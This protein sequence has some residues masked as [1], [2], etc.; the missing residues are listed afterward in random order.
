MAELGFCQ[1]ALLLV[2]GLCSARNWP[3]IPEPLPMPSLGIYPTCLTRHLAK[4]WSSSPSSWF[5]MLSWTHAR[6]LYAS[7]S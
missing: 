5:L 4:C 6:S 7:G 3:A 2:F 1:S